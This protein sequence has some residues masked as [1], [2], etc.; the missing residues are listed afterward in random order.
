MLSDKL[1]DAYAEIYEGICQ[2]NDYSYLQKENLI[3]SMTRINM[4]VYALSCCV[5][6]VEQGD[7]YQGGY[8]RARSIAEHDYNKAIKGIKYTDRKQWTKH[9][10]YDKYGNKK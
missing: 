9:N 7:A 10:K 4:I 6:N 2:Y 3:A 8:D 5:H 1:F